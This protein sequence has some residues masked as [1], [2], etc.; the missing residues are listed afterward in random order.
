MSAVTLLQESCS[1]KQF[2]SFKTLPV[3]AYKI[4]KFTSSQTTYGRKI[5]AEFGS[6]YVFL[7]KNTA[8]YLDDQ[9]VE[10]LNKTPLVMVY[11]G[12]SSTNNR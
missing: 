8:D 9:K 12:K 10:E 11:N 2:V 4:T 1:T 3:G 5:R 7:P 6:Q